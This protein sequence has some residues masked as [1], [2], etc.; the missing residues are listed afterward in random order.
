MS[1]KASKV[2]VREFV[3]GLEA[4]HEKS[5]VKRTG[6]WLTIVASLAIVSYIIKAWRL[7]QTNGNNAS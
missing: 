6:W 1:K 5:L 3:P 4:K 7:S 2:D